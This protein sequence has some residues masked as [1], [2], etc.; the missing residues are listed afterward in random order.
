[1]ISNDN[2]KLQYIVK[3]VLEA[4]SLLFVSV[5]NLFKEEGQIE[6][7]KIKL[8]YPLSTLLLTFCFLDF[9]R[10][11]DYLFKHGKDG[12]ENKQS[13]QNY[14]SFL[15]SFVIGNER[16]KK[17][18]YSFTADNLYNVRNGLVHSFSLNYFYDDGQTQINFIGGT[19]GKKAEVLKKFTELSKAKNP[20]I[21]ICHTIAIESL[22][23]IAKESIKMMF[24]SYKFL[25]L[26]EIENKKEKC[27]LLHL[28]EVF[29]DLKKGTRYYLEISSK[30]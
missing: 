29:E 3:E 26:D 21:P 1:M 25:L 17:Y 9:L 20:M 7:G 5:K 11:I 27:L 15:K 10:R 22:L 8:Y 28:N 6:D 23:E 24:D 16:Y 19:L 30:K 18:D 4:H 12:K 14:V 2:E 13:R